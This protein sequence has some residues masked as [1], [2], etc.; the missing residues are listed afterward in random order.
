MSVSVEQIKSYETGDRVSLVLKSGNEVTGAIDSIGSK[1]VAVRSEPSGFKMS[2]KLKDIESIEKAEEKTPDPI[3][4]NAIPAFEDR[5]L[6]GRISEVNDDGLGGWIIC[7][8]GEKL[9]F[10]TEDADQAVLDCLSADYKNLGTFVRVSFIKDRKKTYPGHYRNIASCISLDDDFKVA[11]SKNGDLNELEFSER[12]GEVIGEI[13]LFNSV[14]EFGMIESA[15]GANYQ[16]LRRN[17]D[18]PFRYM[19]DYFAF[20]EEVK[21]IADDIRLLNTEDIEKARAYAA[22]TT[23]TADWEPPSPDEELCGHI[24]YVDLETRRCVIGGDDSRTYTLFFTKK[25]KAL[26]EFI[27]TN[28]ADEVL[29]T[30]VAFQPIVQPGEDARERGRASKLRLLSEEEDPLNKIAQDA[31]LLS[32]DEGDEDAQAELLDK[33]NLLYSSGKRFHRETATLYQKLLESGYRSPVIL[34]RLV[35]LYAEFDQMLEMVELLKTRGDWFESREKY[36]DLL[37]EIYNQ[38]DYET[39]EAVEPHV[40]RSPIALCAREV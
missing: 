37:L 33:A 32:V 13:R 38:K 29:G 40:L 28:P 17:G 27:E 18:A 5:E 34:R 36:L 19:L 35:T 25:E 20:D 10:Y 31:L 4:E 14:T 6:H 2:V 9:G 24:N 30:R 7:D 22:E 11:I 3:A 8:S 21:P 39:D 15:D 1:E 16:F 23:D 12:D 26:K